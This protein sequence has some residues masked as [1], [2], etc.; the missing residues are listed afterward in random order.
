MDEMLDVHVLLPRDRHVPGT[1]RLRDLADP[2][3]ALSVAWICL[4]RSDQALANAAGNPRR[5]PVHHDGDT[6]LGRY[7][8]TRVVPAGLPG[9]GARW[10]PLIGASGPALEAWR[11]GRRGLGIHGGRGSVRLVPT[12]GCLRLLDNGF[13]G[14]EQ[15]LAGRPATT[16][17]EEL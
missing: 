8:P 9:I 13:E 10:I 1:L 3:R 4:G 17:I 5:D 6:P 2:E 7:A 14:L 15:A 12:A 16:T 11:N